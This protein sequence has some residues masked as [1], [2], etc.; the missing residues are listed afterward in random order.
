MTILIAGDSWANPNYYGP[1]LPPPEKHLQ[2]LL[3]EQGLDVINVGANGG[4]NF[5]S[6]KLVQ[7]WFD[8]EEL[9]NPY[10][11]NPPVYKD[12]KIDYII[13]FHTSPLRDLGPHEHY[14]EDT[15]LPDTYYMDLNNL[16]RNTMTNN[17]KVIAIGG[18]CALNKAIDRNLFHYY[19]DC[20]K[21]DIFNVTL[22]EAKWWGANNKDILP[23]PS[24]EE[25]DQAL[26]VEQYVYDDFDAFPDQGHPGEKP[27]AEL[28]QR[29]MA[30]VFQKNDK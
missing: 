15:V 14:K 1:P 18:C 2:Y 19:I 12:Q 7:R 30:E 28:S 27:H 24:K 8:G 21:S 23:D 5:G 11:Y 6:I 10:P 25:V 22:P 29:L 13:W 26:V 16:I 17:A 9:T 3:E 4:S 20:W